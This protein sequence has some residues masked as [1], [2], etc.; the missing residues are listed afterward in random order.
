MKSVKI[1]PLVLS[2][3]VLLGCAA[4]PPETTPSTDGTLPETSTLSETQPPTAPPTLAERTLSQMTLREKVGQLFLI[5]PDALDSGQ[6]L[7]QI[8]DSASPG[9]T[10]A[11]EEITRMMERYPVGGI[12]L[13]SKNI[14]TAEQLKALNTDLQKAS[15]IPLFLAVDE[16]GGLVAR[17]ARTEALGLPRFQSAAAVGA[18][19]MDAALDMGRTIGGYLCEF[20]FNMDFA[21]VADV[22]TNPE[23]PIIGTRA[24]S[25]DPAQAA[26]LVRSM[27]DGLTESGIIPVFKHFPGHGDTAQDSHA[28]LA[29]SQK[30]LEALKSCEF[31]PFRQATDY[32]C[33]MVGHIALPQLTGSLTPATL[34][35][36]IVRDLLKG[37]LGFGGLVITDSLE[38]GAIRE[39]YS[40][41]DDA[42]AAL[43]AGCD[44]ILMPS[45]LEEAFDSVLF[46]LGNGEL[47]M[48][49][50]NETVLKILEFK[51]QHG[52]L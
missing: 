31:L 40:P 12:I 8:I 4:V 27:A 15:A 25:S 46:A 14:Q 20:G 11:T 42:V 30:D 19:G 38:M 32:D 36:V 43:K 47:S 34:S 18:Q 6:T 24:F 35:P 48:Q 9:V 33:V 52:I 44:I 5:R 50:L 29:V 28:G 39:S 13:F 10:Q 23:N 45:N 17:L 41:G 26:L 37:E 51:D 22:N 2:L 49:W 16:E 1:L 3:C 7:S 21:P